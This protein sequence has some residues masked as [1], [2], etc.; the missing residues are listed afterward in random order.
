[1]A[2]K[3]VEPST[4]NGAKP[5]PPPD[6]TYAEAVTSC[7]W[8]GKAFES[9]AL[10]IRHWFLHHIQLSADCGECRQ[11]LRGSIMS[12]ECPRLRCPPAVSRRACRRKSFA[13][14]K[15]LAKHLLTKHRAHLCPVCDGRFA[16]EAALATHVRE[17]A[18]LLASACLL[19]KRKFVRKDGGGGEPD[20]NKMMRH[21]TNE[22]FGFE[23]H[24]DSAIKEPNPR[25]SGV[26]GAARITPAR[27]VSRLSLTFRPTMTE[28]YTFDHYNCP[29]CKRFFSAKSGLK[30]HSALA[31]R[32]AP[33]VFCPRC[34]T[35][36]GSVHDCK[37]HIKAYHHGGGNGKSGGGEGG[38]VAKK[39][40]ANASGRI[41]GRVTNQNEENCQENRQ[42]GSEDADETAIRSYVSTAINMTEVE[43]GT[44]ITTTTTEGNTDDKIED[45]AAL[46]NL[47]EPMECDGGN[48][49]E[50][51]KS[52]DTKNTEESNGVSAIVASGCE[53]EAASVELPPKKN[54]SDSDDSDKKSPTKGKSR[55]PMPG[56]LKIGQT[57]AKAAAVGVNN[58]PMDQSLTG[59]Q[60]ANI[61]SSPIRVKSMSTLTG[62]STGFARR[63]IVSTTK[64][65]QQQQQL[66]PTTSNAKNN[67]PEII[68]EH[69]SLLGVHQQQQ[70]RQRLHRRRRSNSCCSPTPSFRR[71]RSSLRR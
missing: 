6:V 64:S 41:K 46:D 9:S 45:A 59:E 27:Q 15:R 31:H 26:S 5:A 29:H 48:T 68:V 11:P 56:L 10:L 20:C 18:R 65:N 36:F 32:G 24:I 55:K 17:E 47:D 25:V 52:V 34:P 62:L 60:S 58:T 44:T 57:K 23:L 67:K 12:H 71:R 22:H 39:K 13:T 51:G 66:M 2:V 14:K 63:L 8:C 54:V 61:G 4:T 43:P 19:C 33:V 1:M 38:K 16:D 42:E 21:L 28:R 3:D 49:M 69:E 35:T 40:T 50:G 7:G 53:A 70:R 37:Q 30:I